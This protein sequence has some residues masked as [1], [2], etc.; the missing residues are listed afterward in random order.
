MDANNWADQDCRSRFSRDAKARLKLKTC[1]KTLKPARHL[2][3][4][5]WASFLQAV[6]IVRIGVHFQARFTEP[7]RFLLRSA[8]RSRH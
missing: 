3:N 4:S 5:V 2:A 1:A 7:S 8:G 6:L